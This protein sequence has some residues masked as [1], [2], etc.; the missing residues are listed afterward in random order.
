M[1]HDDIYN[2]QQ[3]NEGKWSWVAIAMW[4]IGVGILFFWLLMYPIYGLLFWTNYGE[5][6]IWMFSS[7]GSW[8]AN[9]DDV[10]QLFYT[11]MA[12]FIILLVVFTPTKAFKSPLT[13][14]WLHTMK[15]VSD[16]SNSENYKNEPDKL[17]SLI[18]E[19]TVFWL[20]SIAILAMY[21]F[22]INWVVETVTSIASTIAI[23]W[24]MVNILVIAWLNSLL[25]TF[26]SKHEP[27]PIYSWG[28]IRSVEKPNDVQNSGSKLLWWIL[29]L[30][31][32]IVILSIW[33]LVSE[34]LS[35]RVSNSN[36]GNILEWQAA[37]LDD[38]NLF[39]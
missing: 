6:V 10:I 33:F 7:S 36:I 25:V 8:F 19:V 13:Y 37:D 12:I 15:G 2:N 11:I 39:R 14:S 32:N 30:V 35:D 34:A 20:T 28:V 24:L 31:L 21:M 29:L 23:L 3:T 17:K 9:K 1:S 22:L 26:L 27:A 4:W 18:F 16:L 38:F 5:W